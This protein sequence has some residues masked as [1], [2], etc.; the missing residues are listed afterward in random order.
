MYLSLE[1]NETGPFIKFSPDFSWKLFGHTVFVAAWT[2]LVTADKFIDTYI[3]PIRP[4]DGY[5]CQ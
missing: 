2:S 4:S 3:R 1:R 5:M